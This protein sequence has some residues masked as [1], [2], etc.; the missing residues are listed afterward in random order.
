MYNSKRIAT[1]EASVRKLNTE[2]Y[3]MQ[4][5][6]R[7]M[8]GEMDRMEEVQR[9]F[10]GFLMYPLGVLVMIVVYR[11]IQGAV[12]TRLRRNRLVKRL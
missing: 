2:V 6:Q 5:D 3:F 9:V 10:F 4:L 12:A 7:S 1:L 11:G 8:I